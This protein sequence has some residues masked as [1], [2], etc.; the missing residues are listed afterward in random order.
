MVDSVHN[1]QKIDLFLDFFLNY[2]DFWG[3][4]TKKIKNGKISV[5]KNIYLIIRN[6]KQ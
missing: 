2:I 4:I 6:S 1:D 5:K 3:K